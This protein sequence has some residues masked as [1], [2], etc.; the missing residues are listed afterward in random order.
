[1]K[2]RTGFVSNSSSSSFVIKKYYLSP[3]QLEIIREHTLAAQCE[4]LRISPSEQD[5]AEC[6]NKIKCALVGKE[7]N[8]ETFGYG[9]L[10]AW[11]ITE[12]D[13]VIKGN[14]SM[15][16]FDMRG[17]LENIGVKSENISWESG[18]W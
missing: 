6:N 15:D 18:H 5:C 13:D 7:D 2:I 11:Q 17:L 8:K 3:H 12:D 10:D 1:M 14:T 16:N 4:K 9:T